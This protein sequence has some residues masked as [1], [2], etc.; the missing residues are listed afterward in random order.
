[1]LAGVGIRVFGDGGQ[2]RCRPG[3]TPAEFKQP[4]RG[5][6][7]GF[8]GEGFTPTGASRS[9]HAVE[10]G[11]ETALKTDGRGPNARPATKSRGRNKARPRTVS[12]PPIATL[13]R[14]L[15]R[16]QPLR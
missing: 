6:P 11:G 13:P 10:A 5:R 12:V 9:R 1:M 2:H 7:E 8:A 16:A 4:P 15:L 3:Q 14:I